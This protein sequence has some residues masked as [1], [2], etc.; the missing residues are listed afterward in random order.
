MPNKTIPGHDTY[1]SFVRQL[2]TG[3]ELNKAF[4]VP[5]YGRDINT[6]R[7]AVNFY[8]PQASMKFRTKKDCNGSLWAM[9]V[10]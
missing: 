4:E 7:S 6:A 2:I 1:A 3:R 5:L 10:A 9:R 8:G